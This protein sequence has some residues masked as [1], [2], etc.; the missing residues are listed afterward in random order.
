MDYAIQKATELGVSRIQLLVLNAVKCGLNTSVI[1]RK[2]DHWQ[3]IAIAACE[4]CGMNIVT[5]FSPIIA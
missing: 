4:Q 3:Q 5:S 1:K 2:I